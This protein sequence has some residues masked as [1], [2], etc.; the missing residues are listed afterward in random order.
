[1]EKRGET[2][3]SIAELAAEREAR[4]AADQAQYQEVLSNIKESSELLPHD[5]Y[6]SFPQIF[7]QNL[8]TLTT[9]PPRRIVP[10]E[11]LL[12]PGED[13]TESSTWLRKVQQRQALKTR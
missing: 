12:R 11:L 3:V 1:M 8:P 6:E 4:E 10:T 2:T 7:S 9:I 5:S 13:V